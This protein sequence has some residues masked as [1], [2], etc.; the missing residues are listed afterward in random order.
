MSRLV[1]LGLYL[2]PCLVAGCTRDETIQTYEIPKPA[3]YRSTARAEPVTEYRTLGAMFPADEPVWFFKFSGRADLVGR[4]EADFDR[5]I[6]SVRLQPDRDGEPQLPQFTAPADW[7]RTGRRVVRRGG[8]ALTIDETLR[9]GPADDPLEIT[10][11]RSG[12][13]VGQN[14]ARWADQVGYKY[15]KPEELSRAVRRVTADGVE[16]LRVDVSGPKNPAAG[17]GPMMGGS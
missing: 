2:T 11:T 15:S 14:V 4:Y 12:G 7:L 13:G 9:F 17:R 16:G 6:A 10:V 5:L 1:N 8:I 3:E